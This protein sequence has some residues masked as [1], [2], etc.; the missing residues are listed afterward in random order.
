MERWGWKGG[1]GQIINDRIKILHLLLWLLFKWVMPLSSPPHPQKNHFGIFYQSHLSTACGHGETGY[2]HDVVR[3]GQWGAGWERMYLSAKAGTLY[4]PCPK[5][6]I[7][8]PY[9]SGPAKI[10]TPVFQM[11]LVGADTQEGSMLPQRAAW[12][13]SFVLRCL[14][15]HILIAIYICILIHN[16]THFICDNMHIQIHMHIF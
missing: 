5:F 16:N 7:K 4:H 15:V 12:S 2:Q 14:C 6:L 13:K 9:P 11:G 1:W 3:A 10:N 8:C